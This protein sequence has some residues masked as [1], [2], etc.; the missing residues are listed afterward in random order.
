MPSSFGGRKKWKF[1]CKSTREV[2]SLL[3]NSSL[4]LTKAILVPVRASGY[5]ATSSLVTDSPSFLGKTRDRKDVGRTPSSYSRLL[6]SDFTS[7]MTGRGRGRGRDPPPS[8]PPSHPPA[9]RGRARPPGPPPG[10][11][12]RGSGLAPPPTRVAGRGERLLLGQATPDVSLMSE[13]PALRDVASYHSSDSPT[14]QSG[15]ERTTS[16]RSP[17]SMANLSRLKNI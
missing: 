6:Y 3:A 15:A 16:E 5:S 7:K 14:F 4:E 10:A 1:K 13:D 17:E 2:S 9:S 8:G 11:S 12:P